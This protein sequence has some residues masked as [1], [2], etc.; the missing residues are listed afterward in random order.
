MEDATVVQVGPHEPDSSSNPAAIPIVDQPKVEEQGDV[1][2]VVIS[3][4]PTK[5]M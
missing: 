2:A 5:E 1:N 4:T 3:N